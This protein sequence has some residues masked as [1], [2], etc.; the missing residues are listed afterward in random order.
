MPAFIYLNE[1]LRVRSGVGVF[2]EIPRV[3]V[4]QGDLVE[5]QDQEFANAAAFLFSP[6][7][8]Y[9]TGVMLTVEGGMYKGTL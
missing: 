2:G 1:C 6:A 4:G 3:Q 7:A 8:G 5:H 9:I